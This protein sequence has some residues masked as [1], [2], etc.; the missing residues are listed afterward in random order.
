MTPFILRCHPSY[1]HCFHFAHPQSPHVKIPFQTIRC[2]WVFLI[3]KNRLVCEC[4]CSNFYLSVTVFCI[5]SQ[6]YFRAS[7][8]LPAA[9]YK[10]ANNHF[11]D[12]LHFYLHSLLTWLFFSPIENVFGCLV[13]L[14]SIR[15]DLLATIT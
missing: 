8:R 9:D 15:R 14:L 2:L 1:T 6:G 10:G 11:T 5:G 3:S 12:H 13:V 4:S 7:L